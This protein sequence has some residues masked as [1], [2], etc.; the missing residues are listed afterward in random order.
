MSWLG[1]ASGAV[2][3]GILGNIPGALAGGYY[4]YKRGAKKNA[5]L[6]KQMD[7][8]YASRKRT[9]TGGSRS[10]NSKRNRKL[11]YTFTGGKEAARVSR[12]DFLKRLGYK[13]GP[14][15]NAVRM[16]KKSKPVRKPERKAFTGRSGKSKKNKQTMESRCLSLGALTTIEQHG[17]V[18]DP[19]CVYLMHSTGSI[20]ELASAINF[21]L[22]RKIM[23]K[24]GFKIT[25]QNNE[26]AVSLPIAGAN[27]QEN[28]S[29]LRFVFTC[30]NQNLDSYHNYVF[31][32]SDD[33]SFS[34]MAR[35]WVDMRNRIIDYIRNTGE[36]EPYKLSVYK[37]DTLTNWVLGA[38]MFLEDSHIE[39]FMKSNMV[40]QNR[41][42][43]AG[44]TG[45]AEIDR[46]DAQPLKGVVYEFKHADPRVRHSALNSTA[47]LKQNTLFNNMQDDGLRL[48]RGNEFVGTT[49][50]TTGISI[51]YGGA[52]EPFVP[53]Y[54][55]NCH[56]SHKVVVQPGEIKSLGY[57]WKLTGKIVNVIKKLRVAHWDGS[58][59]DF[60]GQVGKCQMI[61]L[62]E[63]MRSF[64][65]NKVTVGYER[66]LKIGVI[67]RPGFKQAP[68]ET[69]V[70]A[71][72][73][74]NQLP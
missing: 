13:I 65:T 69:I 73:K 2:L 17:V 72:E 68:I 50:T 5:N 38:E 40:I 29:G 61:G 53:K 46:V 64:T 54:F 3:G 47:T 66:E 21:A 74:N 63:V 71:Q 23:N 16:N 59:S 36:Q 52:A 22:M 32:T 37:R 14:N 30:K 12:A 9:N 8:G 48:V 28:S 19:N 27:V 26:V 51:S 25:N 57:T 33:Q 41:T 70:V 4:G 10:A 15:G 24:A 20:N 49:A 43:G 1:A 55:A 45:N 39:I 6:P 35:V 60:S 62:E 18:S 34:D 56:K 7:S 44:A 67:V 11:G 31:D 58:I 42:L